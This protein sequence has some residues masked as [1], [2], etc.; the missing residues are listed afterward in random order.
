MLFRSIRTQATQ[1]KRFLF[2]NLYRHPKVVEVTTVAARKVQDLFNHYVSNSET[3]SSEFRPADEI[4][5]RAAH[6]IA[7][8]T[9]RYVDREYQKL[10]MG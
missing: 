5:R 9:D 6:Y 8:M 10:S 1:L 4:Y 7:G 2:K 3:I